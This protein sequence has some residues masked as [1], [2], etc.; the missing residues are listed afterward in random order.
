[1][2][3]NNNNNKTIAKLVE[4]G[5]IVTNEALCFKGF[6]MKNIVD[7]VDMLDY[8]LPPLEEH[9]QIMQVA[10][11]YFAEKQKEETPTI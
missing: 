7:V 4:L 2:N 8:Y 6:I 9:C 3:N 10:G 5:F 11:A 1:M